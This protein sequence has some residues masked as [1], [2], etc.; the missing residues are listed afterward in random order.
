MA[1]RTLALLRLPARI[2]LAGVSALAW[3]VPASAQESPP[4]AAGASGEESPE[5]VHNE[6]DPTVHDEFSPAAGGTG[7]LDELEEIG[8]PDVSIVAT[9]GFD[10]PL[11]SVQGHTDTLND[12]IGLR[13]ATAYT[14]LG[15]W[16]TG[17][18]DDPSGASYD[19]DLMSAW[20]LVGR[21]TPDT[22][23]LVV[24]G[25]YRDAFN[26]DPASAIGAQL[27][28]LIN[29][30]HTF[31]DRGWV[32]RDALWQQRFAGDTVRLLI[33]RAAADDYIGLQP[34]QNQNTLFVSRH[35]AANPTITFPG[36]GPTIGIS[37]R[38]GN[39]YLTAGI[40]SA[41]G[42]STRSGWDTIDDGD[43]FYSAEA[44]FTPDIEGIG[45]GRYSVMA[46]YI[47]ARDQ[48]VVSPSDHG[49][50]LVAGQSLNDR[51]QV[52]GR[53]AYADATTTNVRQI[54]QGGLGYSGNF[55]SSSN[56]T[57]AALSLAQP[58]SSASR[59][60]LAFEVFQR[61]QVTQFTQVTAGAQLIFDPGNNPEEDLVA[62]FYARLRIAF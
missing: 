62:L 59:D 56:M 45:R 58:R 23:T 2:L 12:R 47:D 51:F 52:W 6:L 37:V 30:I 17:A 32:L 53:Y 5:P 33:G 25:E 35:F 41:Y 10:S 61:L 40:A 26:N 50:T 15:A 57:G 21:G 38:P 11:A 48:A 14:A 18:A 55:G 54:F 31:N 29:P 24:T 4:P 43:Y 16:A 20:T 28:T 8:I 44:G 60:E 34:M 36:H 13:L 27:G 19:F 7:G 39:Y 42:D 49:I 22:G 46:W 1:R 9:T 3:A